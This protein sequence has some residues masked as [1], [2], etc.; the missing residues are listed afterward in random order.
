VPAVMMMN[1]DAAQPFTTRL[2]KATGVRE[3]T[4]VSIAGQGGALATEILSAA[5]AKSGWFTAV[6]MRTTGER[7]MAPVLNDVKVGR[8]AVLP[9]C[10]NQRPAEMLVSTEALF[11]NAHPWIA[12]TLQ[13]LVEGVLMVNTPRAPRDV[14]FPFG[15]QGTVATVDAT[16]ICERVLGIR[17]APFGLTLLGLY[18]RATGAVELAH[19][20]E[21][22]GERFP[23]RMGD[24]NAAGV[25]EAYE[26][27]EVAVDITLPARR[28]RSTAT[29]PD[30]RDVPDR[31]GFGHARLRGATEGN[32]ALA[33]RP[34]LPTIDQSKC[35]C[36]V[37]VTP[38]FCPDGVIAWED[39][40]Y[41]VNY[42]YCKGCG[43]CAAVCVHG[44]VMMREGAAV[45]AGGPACR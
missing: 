45:L 21:A 20:I 2:Q 27:A 9:N 12:E 24:A 39:G 37:C 18:I 13:T 23:G 32:P 22:I 15:F 40:R 19:V 30:P 33:W 1:H 3:M 16:S 10:A 7:R 44:A 4:C 26:R 34:W 42:E 14:A 35:T 25:R 8:S 17:P 31:G 38:T 29:R 28:A 5:F 41:T 36:R 43:I 6:R 11:D